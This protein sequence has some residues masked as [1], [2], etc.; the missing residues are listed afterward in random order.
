LHPTATVLLILVALTSLGA[1]GLGVRA[2][3]LS[4]GTLPCAMRRLLLGVGLALV[5]GVTAILAM[6]ATGRSI[7]PYLISDVTLVILSLLQG[8]VFAHWLEA[9]R[10]RPPDG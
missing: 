9:S 1:Y 4:P 7:S 10:E 5:F 2:L 8:L 6:R 3:R